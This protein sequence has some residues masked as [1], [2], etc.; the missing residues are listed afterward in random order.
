[1]IVDESCLHLT[2]LRALSLL[3]SLTLPNENRVFASMEVS[4]RKFARLQP[5]LKPLLNKPAQCPGDFIV[6]V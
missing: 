5:T 4:E 1:M 2:R 6:V 3:D